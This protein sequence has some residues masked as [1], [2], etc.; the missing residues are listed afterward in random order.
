MERF[1]R[2]VGVQLGKR[3][4]AVLAAV[5]VITGVLS[6]GLSKLEFATGQDSYLNQDSQEAVDNVLFQDTFGG[7]AIVLVFTM[8]QGKTIGD[9][10]TPGNTAA[11]EQLETK[12]RDVPEVSAVL[13]PLTSMIWSEAIAGGPG[14]L[15]LSSASERDPDPASKQLRLDDITLSLARL[16]AV[17]DRTLGDPSWTDFLLYANQGYSAADGVVTAPAQEDKVIRSSLLSTF[18]NQNIAV[19]GIVLTGNATL[20]ELSSATDAVL[21]VMKGT[22]IEGASIVT[23]GSPVYLKDIN[24]YLQGGMLT[25]GALALAIMA[26]ILLV[27]FRV[28]WRLLP[29]LA[30]FV[31]IAWGF[32]ILGFLGISLSLVTIAGMPILIGMGIDFAIQIHNRVEEEVVLDKEAHPIAETVANVGPPLVVAVA[33]AVVS[34]LSLRVSRVP[35]IRDF[36]VLLAIGIAV[37]LAVGIIVPVTVLGAREWHR[38]TKTRGPSFT[39]RIVVTLGSVSTKFVPVLAVAAILLVALGI[40]LESRTK[41]QSDPVR[42]IDQGSEVVADVKRLEEGTGFSTTLGILIEANNV[43]APEVAD[44]LTDFVFDAEARDEVVVS[45][46]LVGT[47]AKVI[48]VPGAT[49]LAPTSDDLK[50]ALEVA[51]PDIAKSLVGQGGLSAQVNL[52]LGPA[53]L[54]KRAVLVKDL[55]ADLDSRLADVQLKPDSILA[56]GLDAGEPPIRAVP[57]GLAVVGVGLLENLK[58]NRMAL[59][60]VAL[61]AAALWLLVRFRSITRT[62]L[63]MVPVIL[64]VGASSAIV[65]GLGIT[66]SPMTTVSGPLVIANCVEFAVLITARYLEERENGHT[67]R[68]A[69]D[70]ASA[71]TGRAF[72]ASAAT[73]IGGF[74]TLVISPLP[75]LRDFGLIVTL[76]IA[77]A[78]L[79]ALV[80][81]PPLLVYADERGWIS[82]E[83]RAK[84]GVRSVRL[85]APAKGR[86]FAV[87]MGAVVAVVAALFALL[88]NARVEQA[89]AVVSDYEA[90]PLPTTTTTT[91]TTIPGEEPPAIDPSTYGTERPT[92]IVGGTLFDLLTAQGVPANQA[93]CTAE[94]LLS[95]VTEADLLAAGIATFS[96]EAVAPVVTA[97]L[98]CQIPQ[99]T[100][101]AVLNAA[102]GG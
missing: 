18:P 32:S 49:R 81:M 68:Q 11:F 16:G 94:V 86:E 40:S 88:G 37:L 28:R 63:T 66:L 38:R 85:A 99:E 20:D 24:D 36:G 3:W 23:T 51:P 60:Y 14:T 22:T 8:D 64:A 2:G 50:A 29:L 87:T 67:A 47:M 58:A 7:E 52:R 31:G 21:E 5:I 96:D 72:F 15:A 6:I 55:E 90:V 33:G 54:E 42:W 41:I 25:L 65:S 35:M 93:V 27:M 56:V 39:E 92:G 46:S 48:D 69:T 100:L 84:Q 44:V 4:Y 19:G 79:A 83:E 12:L 97:A 34:F 45:S 71:R 78:L 77:I 76:N 101:D 95:R 75:L 53:D 89:T 10:F 62:L 13:T 91:T 1:W 74:A 98:D 30:V 70:I 57:S 43:L 59:T 73:T 82:L 17:E 61:A 102:R 80:L 26:V 9:L